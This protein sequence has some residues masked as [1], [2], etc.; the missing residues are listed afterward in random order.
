MEFGWDIRVLPI[1]TAILPL[2]LLSMTTDATLST[3]EY[4]GKSVFATAGIV[5]CLAILIPSFGS[6]YQPYTHYTLE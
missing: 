2:V 4:K 6:L 3:F 5:L 1:W